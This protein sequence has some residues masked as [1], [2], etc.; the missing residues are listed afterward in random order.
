VT[1]LELAE[2][3]VEFGGVRVLDRVT[4]SVGGGEWL[5]LIGPNGA[6]KTSLLRA[7]ARLVPHTGSIMLR[8][9]RLDRLGRRATA[10]RI[11]VVPQNPATPPDLTVVEYVL[12][13]R[14]PYIPYAGGPGRG[15]LAA[16]ERALATLELAAFAERPLGSLSGGERQRVVL[17]RALAQDA[18]LL[19]LDE[20]TSSL[21]VG[22]QQQ[23]LELVESLRREHE[24]T[25][26]SAT[27]ELT[28]AGQYADRLVLLDGGRQ[29]ASGAPREV[30]RR[31]LIARHYGASVRVIEGEGGIAVVPVRAGARPEQVELV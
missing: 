21:D 6:G 30:L 24:L 25:V 2:V 15:D 22:R 1:S 27:H 18:P 8:G 11:A 29:V 17:A 9:E 4:L 5:G 23:A 28:L 19:L 26:V 14:T 31:D 20:P 10:R 12:L 16:V 13:G 3:S 7:V